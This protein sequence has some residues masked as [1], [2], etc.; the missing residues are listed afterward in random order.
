MKKKQVQQKPEGTEARQRDARLLHAGIPSIAAQLKTQLS[1]EAAKRAALLARAAPDSGG[2]REKSK[3]A[4]WGKKDPGCARENFSLVWAAVLEMGLLKHI[5]A[6]DGHREHQHVIKGGSLLCYLTHTS[7]YT[8]RCEEAAASAHAACGMA[9]NGPPPACS[10][11]CPVMMMQQIHHKNQGSEWAGTAKQRLVLPC[12]DDDDGDDGDGAK[13]VPGGNN[14]DLSA[15]LNALCCNTKAG[16][17]SGCSQG[18][19]WELECR[20]W[21]RRVHATGIQKPRASTSWPARDRITTQKSRNPYLVAHKGQHSVNTPR[22]LLS[23]PSNMYKMQWVACV[24]SDPPLLSMHSNVYE[25]QGHT[26][27]PT[28]N[29]SQITTPALCPK[30]LHPILPGREAGTQ[31]QEH[32]GAG[33]LSGCQTHSVNRGCPLNT[34][35]TTKQQIGCWHAHKQHA[36]GLKASPCTTHRTPLPGCCSVCVCVSFF[37]TSCCANAKRDNEML[38]L[39]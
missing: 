39:V 34:C 14:S 4:R 36:A 8:H 31:L 17:G 35:T 1:S 23:M 9:A 26:C 37:K 5:T 3:D 20:S 12:D 25:M 38:M 6:T 10:S 24:P 32:E 22:P 27:V 29:P 2:K 21:K 11:I 19:C 33:C 16:K 18:P 28:Q 15:W 30:P 7:T 13:S